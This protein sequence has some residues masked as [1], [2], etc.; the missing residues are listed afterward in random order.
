M[1]TFTFTYTTKDTS[2]QVVRTLYD[3]EFYVDE[4]GRHMVKG[5]TAKG[6]LSYYNCAQ[7]TAA[8]KDPIAI[9]EFTDEPK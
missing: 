7:I 2:R 6:A 9:P 3:P 8:P 5:K 1:K 4:R